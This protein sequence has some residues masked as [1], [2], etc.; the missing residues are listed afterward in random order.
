MYVAAI[1]SINTLASLVE[2]LLFLT[3]RRISQREL[4]VTFTVK[5]V[6]IGRR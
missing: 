2:E 4:C 1:I 3:Q 6:G 5:L